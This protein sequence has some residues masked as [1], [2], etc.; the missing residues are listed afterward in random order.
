MHSKELDTLFFQIYQIPTLLGLL[1]S[2]IL[3]FA[4]ITSKGIAESSDWFLF[5]EMKSSSNEISFSPYLLPLIDRGHI[6]KLGGWEHFFLVDEYL[7]VLFSPLFSALNSFSGDSVLCPEVTSSF[8]WLCAVVFHF[9][10]VS[11][12]EWRHLVL[13]KS[14]TIPHVIGPFKQ[15]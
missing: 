12:W 7:W 14:R 2:D 9:L 3:C 11:S 13:R 1:I 5:K 10:F 6:G 15:P 8:L 4:K